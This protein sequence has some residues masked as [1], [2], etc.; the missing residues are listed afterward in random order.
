LRTF[1]KDDDVEVSVGSMNYN[2][3][4][5]V[6]G[7]KKKR[8][9]AN[10]GR[11]DYYKLFH[12]SVYDY[13]DVLFPE[14]M[15]K[16]CDRK[17]SY[18]KKCFLNLLYFRKY[19]IYNIDRNIIEKFYKSFVPTNYEFFLRKS[20]GDVLLANQNYYNRQS[21]TSL[22]SFKARYGDKKGSEKFKQH[23]DNIHQQI[24]GDNHWIRRLTI[25]LKEHY[26]IIKNIPIE[27]VKHFISGRNSLIKRGL[28]DDEIKKWFS[29][30]A[31]KNYI[32]RTPEQIESWRILNDILIQKLKDEGRFYKEYGCWKACYKYAI[33]H[34]IEYSDENRKDIWNILFQSHDIR[35]WLNK[36]YSERDGKLQISKLFKHKSKVSI[37]CFLEL[38]EKFNIDIIQEFVIGRFIVDGLIEDKNIVIE[39][40]GD[41]WHLNPKIYLPTAK[42]RGNVSAEEVWKFDESR[43]QYLTDLGYKVFVIWETDWRTNKNAIIEQFKIFLNE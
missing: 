30:K 6:T 26:S 12:D 10:E 1:V 21:T 22:E 18:C 32:P 20:N 7:L 36:G 39:F 34:N 3:L 11:E 8:I 13:F 14:G 40:F 25:P 31:K 19:T 24:S 5:Q 35:F 42:K 27:E 28:T 41:Y 16:K 4:C 37:Q 38:K 15:S 9:S 2:P 33:E 43:I 23:F 29:D 17:F